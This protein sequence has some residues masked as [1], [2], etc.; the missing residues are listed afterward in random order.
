MFFHQGAPKL[1]LETRVSVRDD[2]SWWA[3]YLDDMVEE[4]FS[5]IWR[6]GLSS[7]GY[8]VYHLREAANH[9]QYGTEAKQCRQVCQ[10]VH[11][12]VPPWNRSHWN[13]LE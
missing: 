3:M 6:F 10:E 7:Q 1:A 2:R 13:W 9:Y 5:Y 11:S 4:C 8:Q 12:N